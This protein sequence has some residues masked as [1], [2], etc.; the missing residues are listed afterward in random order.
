MAGLADVKGEML[1]VSRSQLV[2]VKS[3]SVSC[4]PDDIPWIVYDTISFHIYIADMF[5]RKELKRFDIA[6]C[7]VDVP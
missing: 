7:N 3:V 4:N 5:G 6:R 1:Q 2:C